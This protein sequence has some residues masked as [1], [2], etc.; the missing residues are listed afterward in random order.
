MPAQPEAEG[1]FWL[2][3]AFVSEKSGQKARIRRE[4]PAKQEQFRSKTRKTDVKSAQKRGIA[5]KN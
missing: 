4:I 2:K 5:L 3:A 1:G